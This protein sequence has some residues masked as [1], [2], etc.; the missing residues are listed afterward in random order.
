MPGSPH[1]IAPGRITLVAV[2][3]NPVARA[4][5][6]PVSAVTGLGTGT[7]LLLAALCS[8]ALAPT[9]AAG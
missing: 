5:S 6:V 9:T 2:T 8:L 7:V 4:R 1:K 3:A